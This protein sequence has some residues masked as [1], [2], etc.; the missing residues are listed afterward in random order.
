MKEADWVHFACHGVQDTLNLDSGLC[1]A[2]GRCLKI[3]DIHSRCHVPM[4]DLP[5]CQTTKGDQ[6][7]SDEAIHIAP[8]MLFASYSGVI[9]TVM[10]RSMMG[11]G[12]APDYRD[13]AWALHEAIGHLREDGEDGATFDE[14]LPFIHLG[15]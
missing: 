15:L 8:G 14:W 13:A 4:V 11:C 5:F 3:S 2:N 9:G 6:A 7:L 10:W 12:E 1:L